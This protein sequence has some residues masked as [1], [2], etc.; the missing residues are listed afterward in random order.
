MK[1]DII[2]YASATRPEL[3]NN[4]TVV[5][6]DV[7]RATSVM[8]TALVNGCKEVIPV[9]TPD[10]AVQK[11]LLYPPEEVVLGGERNAEKIEGFHLGNSPLDYTRN[12]VE[13][14]TV[15]I[16]TTNGTK[17]LNSCLNAKYVYIGAFLNLNALVEEIKNENEVVLFCSGTN[18]TFSL[19]DGMCAA[20]IINLLAKEK[21][22]NL[23][24]FAHLLSSVYKNDT[25]SGGTLLNKSY[26]L[27]LLKQ[28]GY[29]KDVI[30][31]LQNSLYDIT[32]QM[33][34]INKSIKQN[35]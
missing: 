22:L 28:K 23:T 27:N 19:D 30:F 21:N 2:P 31:C 4:K 11:S 3:T 6:I 9:M 20:A 18:N 33:N 7:L 5:V 35:P 13:N 16:T 29:E 24:D 12:A 1:I 34:L 25:N 14:K 8:L 26:H 32:P 10:E 17:A 15:I